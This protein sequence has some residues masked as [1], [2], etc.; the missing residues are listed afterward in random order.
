[1]QKLLGEYIVLHRQSASMRFIIYRNV[2]RSPPFAGESWINWINTWNTDATQREPIITQQQIFYRKIEIYLFER[3]TRHEKQNKTFFFFY[4]CVLFRRLFAHIYKYVAILN[5]FHTKYFE[6][7]VRRWQTEWVERNEMKCYALTLDPIG[8]WS[9]DMW[10][11]YTST[12]MDC[13]SVASWRRAYLKC[14][15]KDEIVEIDW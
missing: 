7:K 5:S 10:L 11:E 12:V 8:K 1:M 2:Y 6:C 4:L 13:P 14:K 9:W 3:E 15:I